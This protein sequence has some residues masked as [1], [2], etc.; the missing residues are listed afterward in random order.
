MPI[1]FGELFLFG[2]FVLALLLVSRG[3]RPGSGVRVPDVSVEPPT[4]ASVIEDAPVRS[5]EVESRSQVAKSTT[6]ETPTGKRVNVLGR[7]V[8]FRCEEFLI[9]EALVT[10]VQRIS[11]QGKP[12]GYHCDYREPF[13]EVANAFTN[14]AA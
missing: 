9:G 14:V 2:F 12:V 6:V 4:V 8:I 13:R 7:G 10:R 3:K 11:S 1:R 5:E